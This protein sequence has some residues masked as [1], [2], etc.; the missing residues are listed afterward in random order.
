MTVRYVAMLTAT[1]TADT[2]LLSLH[3][4]KL[5]AQTHGI[6]KRMQ[7]LSRA[8]CFATQDSEFRTAVTEADDAVMLV[9]PVEPVTLGGEYVVGE[10][11]TPFSAI[12]GAIV[13]AIDALFKIA[14]ELHDAAVRIAH[15]GP[16]IERV[17]PDQQAEELVRMSAYSLRML[18]RELRSMTLPETSACTVLTSYID[19]LHN[20][21]TL[22]QKPV[23]GADPG[24][25]YPARATAMRITL[26]RGDGTLSEQL[27][28]QL[29]AA[30]SAYA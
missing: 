12:R 1:N 19:A 2:Q 13:T 20:L 26:A 16:R 6:Y 4:S 27:L 17:N 3:P 9:L 25:W 21:S 23:D 29:A 28:G 7:M 5:I 30:V 15:H 8:V 24:T 11:T 10:D 14:H 22:L 18:A